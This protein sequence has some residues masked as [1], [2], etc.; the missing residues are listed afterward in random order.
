[1]AS[2]TSVTQRVQLGYLG[3]EAVWLSGWPISLTLVWSTFQL[4]RNKVAYILVL[5][6]PLI[7]QIH[8]PTH[9]KLYHIL[10]HYFPP[11]MSGGGRG[12]IKCSRDMTG[13]MLN[14]GTTKLGLAG[15]SWVLQSLRHIQNLI[16][17]HNWQKNSIF[18]YKS[19]YIECLSMLV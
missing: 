1:M 4:W 2:L 8:T 19:L 15:D 10:D 11:C 13:P 6:N 17:I 12:N 9:S 18:K 7:K 5:T 14:R 3:I 16:K